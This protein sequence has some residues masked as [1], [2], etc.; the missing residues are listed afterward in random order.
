MLHIT[1][2]SGV[3]RTVI[4]NGVSRLLISVYM[5]LGVVVEGLYYVPAFVFVFTVYMYRIKINT[6]PS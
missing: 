2:K 5:S 1:T 3:Y 4:N 6:K